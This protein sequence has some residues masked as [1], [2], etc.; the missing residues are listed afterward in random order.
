MRLSTKGKSQWRTACG[1][2]CL[3]TGFILLEKNVLRVTVGV[4]KKLQVTTHLD[5]LLACFKH[6]PRAND[7]T[8]HANVFNLP[9]DRQL[10][11]VL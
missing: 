9:A 6:F 5:C 11:S 2:S 10:D 4:F 1:L 3:F 7:E 8:M